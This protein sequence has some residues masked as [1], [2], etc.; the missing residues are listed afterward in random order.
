MTS[1]TAVTSDDGCLDYALRMRN[2][3]VW[4]SVF[5]GVDN[6]YLFTYYNFTNDFRVVYDGTLEWCVKEAYRVMCA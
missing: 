1:W 3:N 5:N 2:G 6:I 4:I